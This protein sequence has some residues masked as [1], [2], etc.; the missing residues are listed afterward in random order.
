MSFVS[1]ILSDSPSVFY[2]L[3]DLSGTVMTDSSGNA[4][5]GT[6]SG[7]YTLGSTSLIPSHLSDAAIT[8]TNGLGT[9]AYDA[10]WLASVNFSAIATFKCPATMTG[11]KGII[12]RYNGTASAS[13]WALRLNA[14][15]LILTYFVGGGS[16]SVTIATGLVAGDVH[17][18]GINYNGTTKALRV[19]FDGAF[20]SQTTLTGMN[21]GTP[22]FYVGKENGA[23]PY[24]SVIDAVAYFDNNVLADARFAAYYAAAN[25]KTGT[26]AATL[27]LTTGSFSGSYTPPDESGT[28]AA[29]LPLT[30]ASFTGTYT[31]P[32]TGTFAAVLP[33]TTASFDGTYTG[34]VNP[35][36]TF[37][38]T[39][40]L[41]TASF[42][43]DYFPHESGT[44]AATIPL[45]TASFDGTYTPPAISGSFA[46]T[47]PLIT[48]SFAGVGGTLL[49]SFAAT[50]PLTTAR[51][52]GSYGGPY[53]TDTSNTEDGLD[54]ICLGIVTVTR[55]V[56]APP[57]SLVLAQK[58]DLAVAY[59]EPDMDNG[60]PT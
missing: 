10:A 35:T 58:Y 27:P 8:W 31:A 19:F 16:S 13:R 45:T 56:A 23:Q 2:D 37:A 36:G 51:F 57:A 42:D 43:G 55:P 53:P 25:A 52:S 54:I 12:G 48:A 24:T 20:V 28:F 7:T 49:G 32:P 34:P 18:V 46:A 21:A 4:R 38:A 33:L 6:L 3:G 5:H 41:I 30:T 14:T 9:I 59:P 47:L 40:P 22:A 29:V 1:E 26:F 44:F 17:H 50:L 11:V 39:L 15:S 60:R